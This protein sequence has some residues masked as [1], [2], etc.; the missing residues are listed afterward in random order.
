V[1]KAFHRSHRERYGHADPSRAVEIVSVRLRGVG[2]TEKPVI[3][4]ASRLKQFK[5]RPQRNESGWL[6]E[7][8][9]RISVYDRADLAPGAVIE[10]PAIIIE[11][12]STT[13]APSGWRAS[14]DSWNNLIL[15]REGSL[16]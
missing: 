7:K 16:A 15:D 1:L 12:G 2:V 5:A 4:K 10:T 13:L 14:V 8:R 3:E 6:G 9:S 11:Y